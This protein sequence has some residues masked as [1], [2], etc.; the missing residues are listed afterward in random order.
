VRHGLEQ[1][2][3]A[4]ERIVIVVGEPAFYWRFGFTC[5]AVRKLESGFPQEFFMALELVPGALA[6]V[7]GPVRYAPAFGLSQ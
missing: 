5:D 1:L 4:G 3:T 7:H 2:R 6:G